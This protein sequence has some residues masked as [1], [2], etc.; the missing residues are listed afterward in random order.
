[1]SN[2]K[3][4]LLFTDWYEPGFKAGGPIQSCKNIVKSLSQEYYFYIF[5]SDRD[6]GD[7]SA[8]KNIE[9][10]KWIQLSEGVQIWYASPNHLKSAVVR[11]I[12]NQTQPH[13]VYLNSMFS[14]GFSLLPLWVLKSMNW[15]ATTI[16]APR[17][18]LNSSALLKKKWKKKIFLSLFSFT[19]ISRK[20]FFHATDE[21]E[22]RDIQKRFGNKVNV[23]LA[24][25]IPNAFD[26]WNERKKEPGEL[27][28]VFV[29]RIHPIK[30]LLFALK[31]LRGLKGYS[32]TFDVYGTIEDEKYF[33]KC[34]KATRDLDS[35]ISVNFKGSLVHRDLFGVLQQYHLFF[36]P[37]YGENFGHVIFESL[38]A[39]CPVL[40][41]D[42]TPWNDIEKKNAGWALPLNN[43]ERFVEK[44]RQVGNMDQETYNTRSRAAHDYANA[45]LASI[46]YK[47]KYFRLFQAI[48]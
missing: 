43:S 22:Q 35:R 21:Q 36:L 29:S 18:M 20:L 31:I 3:T 39:G 30:N 2:K 6:L 8:Y 17:G 16:L 28:C 42:K 38:S 7:T 19:G 44:V 26:T 33:Q 41:S 25:N 34:E 1:M 15:P 23:I 12:I 5:T 27:K 4:I 48:Q 32:V 45:Y 14:P 24:E 10:D 47:D 13:V 9:T 46:D 37:T 11:Q 40:I